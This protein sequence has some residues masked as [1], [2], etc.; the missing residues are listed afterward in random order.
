MTTRRTRDDLE[1]AVAAKGAVRAL[2]TSTLVLVHMLGG[3][4]T[5]FI[6]G[7]VAVDAASVAVAGDPWWAAFLIV[8]V[9][10]GAFV[11]SLV[12]G[13]VRHD[14]EPR[15][16]AIV[17][18]MLVA[19]S[20]A[21][22]IVDAIAP[23]AMLFVGGFGVVAASMHTRLTLDCVP[24]RKR[25]IIRW[26]QWVATIL[27]VV[28]AYTVGTFLVSYVTPRHGVVW[29]PLV[30]ISVVAAVLAAIGALVMPPSARV[31]LMHDDLSGGV[32]ALLRSGRVTRSRCA[33]EAVRILIGAA[34]IK[35]P[36][37]RIVG[38]ARPSVRVGLMFAFAVGTCAAGAWA[39][40]APVLLVEAGATLV[41]AA[42]FSLAGFVLAAFALI[43]MTTPNTALAKSLHGNS[44]R[45]VLL[46]GAANVVLMVIAGLAAIA[47]PRLVL[48][49]SVATALSIALAAGIVVPAGIGAI[50]RWVPATRLRRARGILYTS[51][52]VVMIG[53]AAVAGAEVVPVAFIGAAVVHA[54]GL[55]MAWRALVSRPHP[56]LDLPRRAS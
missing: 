54:V 22:G 44:E 5:G 33:D 37:P 7:A 46:A 9:V 52:M 41:G 30:V 49:T 6:L 26:A 24:L 50:R 35:Q 20:L 31:L 40:G 2:P 42:T 28:L 29:E 39:I 23:V 55:V 21:A 12:D 16:W 13:R 15:R 27:G 43:L 19:C 14:A 48:V 32:H 34:L 47:G 10:I 53:V 25:A 45:V 3:V 56:E 11:G 38:H 8:A 18:W 17:A 4:S 51:Q 36:M 1:A